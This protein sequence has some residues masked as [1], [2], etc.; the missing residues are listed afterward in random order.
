MSLLWT[1]GYAG[2]FNSSS[3]TLNRVWWTAAYTVR[4]NLMQDYFGSILIDRG[5]RCVCVCV[6]VCVR[7]FVFVNVCMFECVYVC[8]CV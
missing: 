5:G 6:C 3:E 7:V 2:A 8:M 4:L 1:I